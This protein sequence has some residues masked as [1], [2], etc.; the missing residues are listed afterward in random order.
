MLIH[1]LGRAQPRHSKHIDTSSPITQ[2]T[3]EELQRDAQMYNK[4]GMRLF[5]GA[6]A[7]GCL[8]LGASFYITVLDIE[9]LKSA[10]DKTPMLILLLVRGTLFGGLSV[11]LL[12]GA[13]TVA[14]AFVD[15]AARFRKRF[16]SAHMIN[17]ALRSFHTEIQDGEVQLG[18]VVALFNAWNESVES[19]F[20]SIRFQKKS[21][22]LEIGGKQ[23]NLSVK[24]PE[25]AV[26]ARPAA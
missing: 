20:S 3:L 18:E 11:A 15:Q 17:Y 19:A 22:S 2:A 24:E 25:K 6:L 16:Y 9:D 13:M 21:Q 14:T 8:L 26:E 4:R 1:R 7:I 5:V 12:Y 23:F 10:T